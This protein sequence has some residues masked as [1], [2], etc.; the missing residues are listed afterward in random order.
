MDLRIRIFVRMK[1]KVSH[2]MNYKKAD[3]AVS[4]SVYRVLDQWGTVC[5]L[6]LLFCMYQC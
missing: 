3:T 4:E 5:S 1:L 2:V 6:Y